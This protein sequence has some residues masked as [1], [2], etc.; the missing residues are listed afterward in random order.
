MIVARIHVKKGKKNPLKSYMMHCL[1]PGLY[2]F[3]V[4]VHSDLIRMR[5]LVGRY[6]VSAQV[7]HT[8]PGTR[9]HMSKSNISHLRAITIPCEESGDRARPGLLARTH[10]EGGREWWWP[11]SE[12]KTLCAIPQLWAISLVVLNQNMT[13]FLAES[14]A[15]A[16]EHFHDTAY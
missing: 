6:F 15:N 9:L 8:P 13:F 12:M 4:C 3:S 1:Q 16:T 2:I 10:G 7:F 14:L 5:W 11:T